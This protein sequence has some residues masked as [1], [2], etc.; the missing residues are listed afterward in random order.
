MKE[1]KWLK[2]ELKRTELFGKTLEPVGAGGYAGDGGLIHLCQFVVGRAA[3]DHNPGKGVVTLHAPDG[4]S[5]FL[6]GGGR[7]AAG[8]DY[9]HIRIIRSRCLL[10]SKSF[11]Q[12]LDLMRIILVD[13]ATEDV[14]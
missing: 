11:K 6:G 10:Q 9:D 2:K 13:L 8:V 7:H 14:D 5:R 1:G 12:T 4:L 3:G